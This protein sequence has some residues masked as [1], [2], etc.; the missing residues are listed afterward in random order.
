MDVAVKSS[1][2]PL[3]F[4]YSF[5][6]MSYLRAVFQRLVLRIPTTSEFELTKQ[7][8]RNFTVDIKLSMNL[9]L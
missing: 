8:E 5:I 2:D 9:L 4:F 1:A 3:G 7:A 6:F